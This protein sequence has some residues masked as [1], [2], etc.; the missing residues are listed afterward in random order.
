MFLLFSFNSWQ[1][2]LC[3]V[4]AYSLK[5]VS[6]HLL[7]ICVSFLCLISSS[8][9]AGFPRLTT[10]SGYSSPLWLSLK[11]WV[12]DYCDWY[13][14]TTC[15]LRFFLLFKK[16][17]NYLWYD[18]TQYWSF[19]FPIYSQKKFGCNCYLGGCSSILT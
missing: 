8:L 4:F 15:C 10:W 16:R 5:S 12:Y 19:P 14:W 18:P 11:L 17:I 9:V 3:F 7:R 1:L 13:A 6:F 2:I